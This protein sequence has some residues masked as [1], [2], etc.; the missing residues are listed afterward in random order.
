MEIKTLDEILVR[1]VLHHRFSG[2]FIHAVADLRVKARRAD[3][4]ERTR[5]LLLRSFRSSRAQ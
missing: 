3:Q 5:R 2:T 4:P 1:I